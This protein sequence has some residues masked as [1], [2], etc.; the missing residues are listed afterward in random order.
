MNPGVI[1]MIAVVNGAGTL[2]QQYMSTPLAGD[3]S[4]VCWQV[5]CQLSV[6]R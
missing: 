4:V 1:A 6:G 2:L 5:M 3:V